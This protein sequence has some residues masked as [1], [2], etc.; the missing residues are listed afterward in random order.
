MVVA[1]Q[2]YSCAV[3]RIKQQRQL[4]VLQL[5][6]VLEQYSSMEQYKSD[7]VLSTEAGNAGHTVDWVCSSKVAWQ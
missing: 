4:L 7:V 1:R 6:Q 3:M 2:L 5:K